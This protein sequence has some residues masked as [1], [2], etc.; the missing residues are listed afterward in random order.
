VEAAEA[1]E[2]GLAVQVLAGGLAGG[3]AAAVT[4]PL[5]VVKTRLQTEG[6]H[7]SRR[8]ATS[9]VVGAGFSA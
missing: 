3:A 6:M 5:D 9:A 4:N 1:E 2:E 7:S 8:Y